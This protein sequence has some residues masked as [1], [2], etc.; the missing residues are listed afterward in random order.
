M[1]NKFDI[2][3]WNETPHFE[4]ADGVKHS[5]VS[6]VKKYSGQLQGDAQLEYL[7]VGHACWM[8]LTSI[9]EPGFESS[10]LDLTFVRRPGVIHVAYNSNNHSNC[11]RIGSI[12]SYIYICI[13]TAY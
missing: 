1:K 4:G 12:Y 6:V 5:K 10:G 11:D 13:C 9:V 3:S 8:G 2:I 7:M